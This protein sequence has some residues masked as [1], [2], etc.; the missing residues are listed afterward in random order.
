MPQPTIAASGRKSSLSFDHLI[1]N[2]QYSHSKGNRYQWR[3]ITGAIIVKSDSDHLSRF[4]LNSKKSFFTPPM[5]YFRNLFY[6]MK[7]GYYRHYSSRRRS[8]QLNNYYLKINDSYGHYRELVLST[9]IATF[10]WW[11][12]AAKI[13][14]RKKSKSTRENFGEFC[15]EWHRFQIDP[16]NIKETVY[17]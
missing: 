14:L 10:L 13:H 15:F 17:F 8:F 11:P 4:K 1:T 7:Q 6:G 16:T 2:G 9:I 5:E 12:T 3:S